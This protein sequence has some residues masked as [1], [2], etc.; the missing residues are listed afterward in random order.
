M[1]KLA[2]IALLLLAAVA[3]AKDKHKNKQ[4]SFEPVIK[5]AAEYVGV[6]EWPHSDYRFEIE[7]TNGRL[8][9]IFVEAGRVAT[10]DPI[11]INGADFTAVA[12][13]VDGTT[14]ALSG[15]FSNRILNGEKAFGVRLRGV[16]VSGMGEVNTFF[17]RVSELR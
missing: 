3:F 13:F 11:N 16:R 5:P 2:I 15:T 8:H 14:R 10:L 9:G 6:Y 17:E 7:L 4:K 1:R 12:R